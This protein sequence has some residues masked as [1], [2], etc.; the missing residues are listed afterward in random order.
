MQPVEAQARKAKSDAEDYLLHFPTAPRQTPCSPPSAVWD[1][2]FA[3]KQLVLT[4]FRYIALDESRPVRANGIPYS[5]PIYRTRRE[6]VPVQM[7]GSNIMTKVS[8]TRAAVAMRVTI[9]TITTCSQ[10][11]RG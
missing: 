11:E 2:T 6:G 4:P 1:P 9:V 7:V 3:G 10:G 8:A 5:A